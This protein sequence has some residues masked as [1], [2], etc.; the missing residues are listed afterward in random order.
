MACRKTTKFPR[1]IGYPVKA[2]RGKCIWN[3]LFVSRGFR[4][5]LMIINIKPGCLPPGKCQVSLKFACFSFE[6]F[7]LHS[8]KTVLILSF[9]DRNKVFFVV[10]HRGKNEN[11]T[12]KERGKSIFT[13]F[14]ALFCA[15]KCRK[16]KR[17]QFRSPKSC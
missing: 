12:E 8:P 13:L 1:H 3:G 17:P 15:E 4:G 2:Y 11:S 9:Q 6:I 14:F 10:F 5:L 7:S 16:R